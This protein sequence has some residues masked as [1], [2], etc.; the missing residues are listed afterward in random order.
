MDLPNCMDPPVA[1]KSTRLSSR[2]TRPAAAQKPTANTNAPP[3]LP[4]AAATTAV[5]LPATISVPTISVYTTP[6]LQ[7]LLRKDAQMEEGLQGYLMRRVWR[8][9]R[10]S[11]ITKGC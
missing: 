5:P 1:P 6:V 10:A 7:A 4:S 8:V 3:E 2:T 11:R 9:F